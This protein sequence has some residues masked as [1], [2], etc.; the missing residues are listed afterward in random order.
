MRRIA[1]RAIVAVLLAV[2]VGLTMVGTAGVA[3]AWSGWGDFL[4]SFAYPEL[5]LGLSWTPV[6]L[7]LAARR[8]RNPVGWIVLLF[9]MQMLGDRAAT[10]VF[11]Q[12]ASPPDIAVVSVTAVQ[13]VPSPPL[14]VLPA[15]TLVLF[16]DGRPPSRHWWW[17]L[18]PLLALATIA[19][20]GMRWA[21][22]TEVFLALWEHTEAAGGLLLIAGVAGLVAR[23]RWADPVLRQQVRGVLFAMGLAVT[24]VVVFVLLERPWLGNPALALVPVSIGA[25]VVR[26]RLFDLDRL[27]SRTVAY[28]LVVALL[29]GTYLALLVA[30]G[31]VARAVT[32]ESGD[33]VVALSTLA[34]AGLFQP[35]RRRTQL[36]VD[37]RFDRTRYDAA[38]TVDAFGRGLRDETSRD[39]VV[40]GLRA[41][42]G[43][44]FGTRQVG[45]TVV[46]RG[47]S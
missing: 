9:G 3:A 20:A 42:A 17:V 10:A 39:A 21:P 41:V 29:A 28:S 38:A 26:Y 31:M 1:H 37:R 15:L 30:I 46:G 14:T 44:T 33:L 40:E 2:A 5:V 24:V 7:V 32:G 35:V 23:H 22:G 27:I 45:V 11:Q 25:A 43:A 6:G 4:G 18:A 16:P 13:L 8:P 19:S 36:V 34:V 12:L 47:S